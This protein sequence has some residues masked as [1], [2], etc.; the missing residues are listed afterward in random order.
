[1]KK[2]L[3]IISTLLFSGSLF[4]GDMDK[5]DTDFDSLDNNDDGYV[6][7]EEADDNNVWDH[8]S[9]IDKDQDS[10]L[11]RTEFR[12][13]TTAN[14]SAVEKGEDIPETNDLDSIDR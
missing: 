6:S 14:P 5:I 7:Q 11:S 13:Y 4:A 10:R 8:F 12:T 9:K 3:V 2:H 1:M